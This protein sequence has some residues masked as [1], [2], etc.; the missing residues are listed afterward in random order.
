[1]PRW[2]DIKEEQVEIDQD[3][4]YYGI[5]LEEKKDVLDTIINEELQ[6]YQILEL[7]YK[8]PEKVWLNDEEQKKIIKK[9]SARVYEKRLTPAVMSTLAYYYVFH[10]ETELMKIIIDHTAFAVLNLTLTTNTTTIP[11]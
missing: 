4:F 5:N 2:L 1:M 6:R 11:L 8:E 9:I 10:N 7:G 3:N